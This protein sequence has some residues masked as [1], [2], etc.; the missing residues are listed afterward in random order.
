VGAHILAIDIEDIYILIILY[1]R[2]DRVTLTGS[3]GGGEPMNHYT[4]E[5]CVPSTQKHSDKVSIRDVHDFPLWT[6]L[7]TITCMVG[8]VD[9]HMSL[10]FYFQYAL[11]FMEP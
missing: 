7:Y 6:I 9:P 8:S 4:S 5:H 2:G 3:S 1:H 10:S 11:E